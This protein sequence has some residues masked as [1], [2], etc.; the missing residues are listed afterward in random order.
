MPP[1]RHYVS[2][3]ARAPPKIDIGE[4]R[5]EKV[6]EEEEKDDDEDDYM[7][8][9]IP[10]V[11][12]KETA[13]QRLQRQKREALAR[14]A[15]KSK[16]EL[17]AEAAAR[18]EEAHSRSLLE[19]ASSKGSKGLA[20]MA[21]MGFRGGALGKAP[22][23]GGGAGAATEPIRVFVKGDRGGVG[24]DEERRKRARDAEEE[25]VREGRKARK[26]EE[27]EYRERV[28]RERETGRAERQYRAAA[29]L[30]QQLHEA[31][32]E[33]AVA[34]TSA[35]D[36]MEAEAEAERKKKGL[37]APPLRSVN[38]LW[39]GLV[40]EREAAERDRAARRALDESLTGLPGYEDDLDPDDKLAVGADGTEYLVTEDP[41]DEAEDEELEQFEDLE[42]G[43][44][45]V[46]VLEYLRADHK[47]CFWCKCAYSDPEM[48]GC[49]G[50]TEEDHD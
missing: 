1:P 18:R 15:P 33:D 39:R 43:E 8:M 20:M 37:S 50:V 23:E 41:D 17:A 6:E 14:G 30:A 32:E 42:P 31:R 12:E 35:P 47:Y 28:R 48:E 26:V 45:L 13:L 9:A 4:E 2:K 24:L 19:D 5:Q 27:G 21:R 34:S 40:K 25:A 46:R 36:S 49:P 38:V 16:A 44:K 22:G 11:P 7:T 10:A 3:P 29:R